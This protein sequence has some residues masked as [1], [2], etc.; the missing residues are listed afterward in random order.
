MTYDEMAKDV[1][2]FIDQKQIENFTLLGHNIG[3]KTAMTLAC[4]YPERVEG[5][6]SIDTAPKN[7]QKD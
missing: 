1:I 2:R 7:F 5:L 4:K 3:A 6:I